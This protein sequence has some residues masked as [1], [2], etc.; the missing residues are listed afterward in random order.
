[1][2]STYFLSKEKRTVFVATTAVAVTL[3]MTGCTSTGARIGFSCDFGT[4]S[5]VA[6]ALPEAS[7]CARS[8]VT[9]LQDKLSE[10]E[11]TTDVSRIGVVAG[12]LGA[13]VAGLYGAHRDVLLGLGLVGGGSYAYGNLYAPPPYKPIFLAGIDAA[14]CV[15]AM[16]RKTAADMHAVR[17]GSAVLAASVRALA[18]KLDP[19][20]DA[21]VDNNTLDAAGNALGNAEAAERVAAGVLSQE[22]QFANSIVNAAYEISAAVDQ[23]I[24]ANTP[25]LDAFYSASSNVI[26][27]A[28]FLGSIGVTPPPESKGVRSGQPGAKPER[29]LE[30]DDQRVKRKEELQRETAVVKANTA[31]LRSTLEKITSPNATPCIGRARSV[32]LPALTISPA[33]DE[34][35]LAKGETFNLVVSGGLPTYDPSNWSGAEP[36]LAELTGDVVNNQLKFHAKTALKRSYVYAVRDAAGA[37]KRILINPK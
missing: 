20:R 8:L 18:E 22:V 1:M 6:S 26:S 13:A 29:A 25:Q 4:G 10:Q 7:A 28:R 30:D 24:A 27:Q 34:I 36:P 17:A 19:A 33:V 5:A 21:G 12:T 23:Q 9:K 32:N 11:R 2:Q 31:T 35:S 14:V 3:L 37:E 16:G 15:D